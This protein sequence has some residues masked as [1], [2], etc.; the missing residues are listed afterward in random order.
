M[1][2][3]A[4]MAQP[5]PVWAE[6]PVQAGRQWDTG[7]CFAMDDIVVSRIFNSLLLTQSLGIR[8]KSE[9]KYS[10]SSAVIDHRPQV[11]L[12]NMPQTQPPH[13]SLELQE[14]TGLVYTQDHQMY[15]L[16]G[17]MQLALVVCLLGHSF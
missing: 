11:L 15:S 6:C 12:L 17:L 13:S 5:K 3:P 4:R 14:Y 10:P 16:Q 7:I 9:L 1:K 8:T 2:R